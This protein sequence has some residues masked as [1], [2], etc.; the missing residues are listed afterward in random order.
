MTDETKDTPV[1]VASEAD[2]ALLKTK[3]EDLESVVATLS[4]A[5]IGGS[6]V[7]PDEADAVRKWSK[8]L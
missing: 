6:V 5:L 8:T 4:K 1:T 3:V 7:T 2:L